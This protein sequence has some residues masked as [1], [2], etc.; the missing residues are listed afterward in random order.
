M[1][2]HGCAGTVGVASAAAFCQRP[3]ASACRQGALH[4]EHTCAGHVPDLTQQRSHRERRRLALSAPMAQ[5]APG[6]HLM[7]LCRRKKAAPAQ[8]RHGRRRQGAHCGCRR[9]PRPRGAPR[10][11]QPPRPP[12]RPGRSRPGR[13]PA[14]W[15]PPPR[16]L[17]AGA[18]LLPEHAQGCT[19]E[20]RDE[21]GLLVRQARVSRFACCCPLDMPLL[22]SD[23][24]SPGMPMQ[25]QGCTCSRASR[26]ALPQT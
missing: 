16:R 22:V 21:A 15:S 18:R 8:A 17:R 13:P 23:H 19:P 24:G 5:I 3:P 6:W 11:T 25:S 14:P 26:L 7:H 1:P 9:A 10:A 12:P 4:Q 20:V 2:A